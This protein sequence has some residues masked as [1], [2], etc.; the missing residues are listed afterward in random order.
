M[1]LTIA[2]TTL[3]AGA[4]LVGAVQ[5]ARAS[6]GNRGPVC[7]AKVLHSEELPFAPVGHWLV[8]VTLRIL[9]PNG[10]A[11]ETTMQDT[12]PW[13]APPPRQGQTFRLRCD[14]ANPADLH[15]KAFAPVARMM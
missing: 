9:P 3:L 6:A 10:G 11:F 2:A 1:K 14:P 8:K 15:F 4:I 13:Q 7:I 12:M 5:M